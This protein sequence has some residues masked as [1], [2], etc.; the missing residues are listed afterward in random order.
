VIKVKL[1]Q[2]KFDELSEKL[3]AAEGLQLDTTPGRVC[4]AA[5]SGVTVQYSFDGSTVTLEVVH[6][7]FIVSKEYC[8]EKMRQAL[9]AAGCAPE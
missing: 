7:P 6:H 2:A 3:Y 8:E 5:K 9:T 1:D 4:Q